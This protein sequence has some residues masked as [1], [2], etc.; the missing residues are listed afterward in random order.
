MI[1]FRECRGYRALMSS[2]SHTGISS[3]GVKND[4][5]ESKWYKGKSRQTLCCV[6]LLSVAPNCLFWQEEAMWWMCR[7]TKDHCFCLAGDCQHGATMKWNRHER[8]CFSHH[9]SR[10]LASKGFVQ[11][12][13]YILFWNAT[14]ALC[15]KN[16]FPIRVI[17]I[18]SRRECV[19]TQF[20]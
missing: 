11:L 14:S 18:E 4:N 3:L 1:T 20:R 2:F 16:L 12:S 6:F 8:Y 15:I 13:I 17:K 19:S 7:T 10:Y 9:Q 5:H